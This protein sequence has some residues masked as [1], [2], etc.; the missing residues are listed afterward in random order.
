MNEQ[1]KQSNNDR[2]IGIFVIVLVFFG[3]FFYLFCSRTG[4]VTGND[5]DV[6]GTLQRIKNDNQRAGAELDRVQS[7]I[8]AAGTEFAGANRYAH[9]AASIARQ[10]A[11]TIAEC[12]DIIDRSAEHNRRAEQLLADIERANQTPA[13]SAASARDPK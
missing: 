6:Q 5:N 11:E 12:R 13:E 4:D 2:N 10:R 9:R 7:E 3:I 8:E 1:E